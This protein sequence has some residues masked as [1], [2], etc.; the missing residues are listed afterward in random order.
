MGGIGG[1]GLAALITRPLVR[2]YPERIFRLENS[3]MNG[4]V[5]GFAVVICLAC[6]LLSGI[7]P[8]VSACWRKDTSSSIR[9]TGQGSHTQNQT[10]LRA[11][12]VTAEIA[13]ALV[14]SICTGLLLRSLAAVVRVNPGFRADHLLALEGVQGDNSNDSKLNREFYRQLLDRLRHIPGVQDASADRKRMAYVAVAGK[15]AR[16]VNGIIKSGTEYRYF[17][18]VA[19]PS[20]RAVSVGP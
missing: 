10:R 11:I 4:R 17:H 13:I 5:L 12:L 3:H 16:V 2:L 8:A 14:V 19:A 6:W 7:M 1:F 20:G 15:M 18:E 9:T